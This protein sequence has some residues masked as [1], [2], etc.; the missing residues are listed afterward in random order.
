M[1]GLDAVAFAKRNSD[2]SELLRVHSPFNP[3]FE[4]DGVLDAN[5]VKSSLLLIRTASDGDLPWYAVGH[6]ADQ[7]AE[8]VKEH[9]V[10]DRAFQVVE[11]ASTGPIDNRKH[12]SR[13]LV[14]FTTIGTHT[15]FF[16][17]VGDDDLV[18]AQK[19]A[20]MEFISS[21]EFE[22]PEPASPGETR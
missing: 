15:W 13:L 7:L 1:P 10:G 8:Q 22:A 6:R 18:A 19:A 20:F 14:A 11:L 12:K 9:K 4:N 3:N 5:L 16:K 17:L 21:V 2:G